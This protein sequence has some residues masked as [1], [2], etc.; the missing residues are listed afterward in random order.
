[1]LYCAAFSHFISTVKQ[2]TRSI[3][4]IISF[5]SQNFFCITKP[6]QNE[7]IKKH[8]GCV[9]GEHGSW[10]CC[11][12]YS[13][14][15]LFAEALCNSWGTGRAEISRDYIGNSPLPVALTCLCR[16]CIHSYLQ[17]PGL[18]ILTS[19]Q[20]SLSNYRIHFSLSTGKRH[21]NFK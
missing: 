7:T 6:N 8:F 5:L 11:C 17:C 14:Y 3:F 15:T 4:T 20:T 21:A 1:M 9:N 16:A 13:H 18:D 19:T 10:A 2:E 12:S